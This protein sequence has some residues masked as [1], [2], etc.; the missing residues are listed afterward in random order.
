M[1]NEEK[2]IIGEKISSE[3][4]EE[5]VNQEAKSAEKYSLEATD[6]AKGAEKSANTA[7]CGLADSAKGV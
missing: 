6:S 5:Q 7:K 2:K 1:S 4:V 3:K